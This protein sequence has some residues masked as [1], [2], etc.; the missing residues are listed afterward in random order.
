VPAEPSAV[1]VPAHQGPVSTA[2]IHTLFDNT[3]T[4][5]IASYNADHN[6]HAPTVAD[7]GSACVGAFFA[8]PDQCCCVASGPYASGR[9][10]TPLQVIDRF[11]ATLGLVPP[12]HVEGP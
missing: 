9:G 8:P 6:I 11:G 1:A 5:T 2:A 3:S 10:L 4:Y 12:F 7:S